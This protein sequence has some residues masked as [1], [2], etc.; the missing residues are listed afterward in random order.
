[1]GI[2]TLL[3]LHRYGLSGMILFSSVFLLHV[4]FVS[5]FPTILWGIQ[6]SRSICERSVQ[7]DSQWSIYS[8]HNPLQQNIKIILKGSAITMSKMF[9]QRFQN[10]LKRVTDEGSERLMRFYLSRC[11][12]GCRCATLSNGGGSNASDNRCSSWMLLFEKHELCFSHLKKTDFTRVFVC[13]N[14]NLCLQELNK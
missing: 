8:A 14:N 13:L 7:N 9:Y 4:H 10:M 6:V 1:M 3:P 12:C 11:R 5:K 2:E